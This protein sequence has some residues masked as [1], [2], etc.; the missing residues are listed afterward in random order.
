MRFNNTVLLVCA[1]VH[2][3]HA[4]QYYRPFAV[5]SGPCVPC[6]SIIPSVCCVQW[7]VCAMRFNNTAT[8][9]EWIKHIPNKDKD[10]GKDTDAGKDKAAG[11]DAKPAAAVKLG[12]Q[13]T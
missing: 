6:G 12:G 2:V 13:L 8:R 10:A 9:D 1:V 4:V 11:K 3:C 7:S 5:R